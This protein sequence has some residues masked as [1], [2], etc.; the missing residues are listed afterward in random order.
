MTAANIKNSEVLQP[1]IEPGWSF[2]I[3]PICLVCL[4]SLLYL[5][6]EWVAKEK[7]VRDQNEN[8]LREL[9]VLRGQIESTI[10]E[11][12][13]RIHGIAAVVR[14]NP[15]ITQQQ[16][17]AIAAGIAGDN[18]RIRNIA[19]AR[20]LVITHMFPI[21]GNEKAIGLSYRDNKAQWPAVK[22][23]IDRNALVIAGPI[24][25]VQGG[26]ALIARVPIFL[27]PSSQNESP[28]RKS[29]DQELWGLI[30][31]VID[32][33]VILSF[34]KPF[35]EDG[36]EIALRG[37]DALGSKGAVFYGDPDLFTHANELMPVSLPYGSW[38][39][40]ARMA[41]PLIGHSLEIWVVRSA[42]LLACFAVFLSFSFRYRSRLKEVDAA[43]RTEQSERKYH[44]LYENA[45]DAIFII[46]PAQ[47]TIRDCNQIAAKRLGYERD[48]LL[49][50]PVSLINAD[51]D[52][53]TSIMAEAVKSEGPALGQIETVHRKKD[54]GLMSVEIT[55]SFVKIDG[56]NLLLSIARDVTE[57][58]AQE[59]N[60]K[61]AHE[62]AEAANRTKTEFLANMSHELRTPL[63]AII[64]FSEIM[65]LETYGKL[66]HEK[67]TDYI[68]LIKSSGDHLL[69]LINDILDLSKVEAGKTDL[70]ENRCEIEAT[71][72]AAIRMVEI[73]ANKMGV[74]I[75]VQ[76][77]FNFPD[78]YADQRL[79]DQILYNALS[80]AVKFNRNG[81]VVEVN[82]RL[83]ESDSAICL[84]ILDDGLGMTEEE[85]SHVMEPFN[86]A[87]N[88]LT[89]EKQGTGLGLPLMTALMELHGAR[90]NIS[91]TKG[92]GT[93]VSLIFNRE[94]TILRDSELTIAN[95]V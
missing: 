4:L 45:R 94:R 76:V 55:R 43:R 26:N 62:R 52:T 3:T 22:R 87:Q 36:I 64:G 49:N 47:Q 2:W 14:A 23:A 46:D 56:D 73:P 92:A 1:T 53:V 88:P 39:V 74:E 48:E 84:D 95:S 33:D 79:I 68:G 9:S 18:H 6:L 81:G 21:E 30:S 78:L 70:N 82:A 66:G 44:A 85:L 15:D 51:P 25:L 10:F 13:A 11:E 61:I 5:P 80:N 63:N 75:R 35:E 71:I 57:R 7:E 19:A 91:S 86:Q 41:V 17:A 67:Y 8:L 34:T 58:K 16:F 54:G 40:G 60:L 27:S 32:I 77:P 90:L 29:E 20:D 59:Q 12:T 50:A 42:I 89:K 37:K 65:K 83:I 31:S 28:A 72:K 69:S 38:E 93:C 24:E